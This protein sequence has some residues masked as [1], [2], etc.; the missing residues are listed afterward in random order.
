MQTGKKRN[1]TRRDNIMGVILRFSHRAK[2]ETESDENVKSFSHLY[3]YTYTFYKCALRD[4]HSDFIF[5]S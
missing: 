5:M 2:S 1:K 4:F 3:S